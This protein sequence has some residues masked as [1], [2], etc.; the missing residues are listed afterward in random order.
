MKLDETSSDPLY[1]QLENIIKNEID[2]GKWKKGEKIS[3]E[4][5]LSKMYNVSRITV[6]KALNSLTQKN[7]LIRRT[8]KGTFVSNDKIQ[9]PVSGVISFSKVC[10]TFGLKSGAKTIKSVIEPANEEDQQK[11]G[12]TASESVIVIERIRYADD[13][14]V[15]VET[16]RFR[17]DFSFLLDE[18]LNNISMY[19]LIDS[20]YHIAFNNSKKFIEIVFASYELSRYLNVPKNYPLL[21]IESTLFDPFNK[22]LC[23]N[24]QYILGDRFQLIV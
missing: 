24:K 3:T 12:L 7:Y 1:L 4:V 20:K 6:R 13:I 21:S 17:E 22:K 5:E 19:K 18:D 10:E 8:G 15:S 23:L 11:L 14:P 9:R 2:C 16:S